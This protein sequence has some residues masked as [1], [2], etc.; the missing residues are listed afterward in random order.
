[1]C[2][3]LHFFTGVHIILPILPLQQLELCYCAYRRFFWIPLLRS[4]YPNTR[5]TFEFN[6]LI[7][8]NINNHS[9][10]KIIK[11]NNKKIKKHLIKKKYMLTT[12]TD[13]HYAF[14]SNLF[15]TLFELFRYNYIIILQ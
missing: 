10:Q 3:R 12:F 5:L 11:I 9:L 14:N 13:I 7:L 4:Y 6:H 2:G 1:M 8:T 15:R